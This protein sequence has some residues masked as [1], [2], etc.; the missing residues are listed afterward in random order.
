M[1]RH[2]V[3]AGQLDQ[4]YHA[5]PF[6]IDKT[7]LLDGEAAVTFDQACAQVPWF[8]IDQIHDQV[9]RANVGLGSLRDNAIRV[10]TGMS[11]AGSDLIGGADADLLVDGLLLDFKSTHAATTVNKSD[12]YQLAGY[13]LLDFD[14]AHR[15]ERVGIY[16]A[17]HGVMRTFA[18]STFFELLGATATVAELRAELREEL[19]AYDDRRR[20]MRL[21]WLE[22]RNRAAVTVVEE[23]QSLEDTRLVRSVRWLRSMLRN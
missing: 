8:V 12:V 3:V 5:Y 18:V 14:D 22:E 20:R 15:I 11:F 13:T 1:I 7:T 23:A 17:R 9:R 19:I 4:L 2:C 21:D 6:V 10:S 16:W